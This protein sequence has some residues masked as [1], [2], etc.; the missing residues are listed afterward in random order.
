MIHQDIDGAGFNFVAR[1]LVF[2]FAGSLLS[3]VEEVGFASPRYG[4]TAGVM[5]GANVSKP[6]SAGVRS[7]SVNYSIPSGVLPGKSYVLQQATKPFGSWTATLWPVT[8]D[9]QLG[10]IQFLS[11]PE[12]ALFFRVS[13]SSQYDLTSSFVRTNVQYQDLESGYSP[14]SWKQT[15]LEFLTR[16]C[17]DAKWVAESAADNFDFWF[18]DRSS[19]GAVLGMLATAVHESVHTVGDMHTVFGGIPLRGICL[20]KDRFLFLP[21][22]TTFARSE[23]ASG[24]PGFMQGD[25][26]YNAYLTGGSGGQD[27]TSLLGEL[28]AYTYSALIASSLASSLP[29]GPGSN[30]TRDGLLTMMVYTELYLKVYREQ[31]SDQYTKLNNQFID[32]ILVLWER[33]NFALRLAEQYGSLGMNDQRIRPIVEQ[34]R[35]EIELVRSKVRPHLLISRGGAVDP[36]LQITQQPDSQ[37][38][39]A[40]GS[41]VFAVEAT[42]PTTVTQQWF[43]NGQPLP[44]ATNRVLVIPEVS[45]ANV[46]TYSVRITGAE[47][48]VVSA[49]ALLEVLTPAIIVQQPKSQTGIPAAFSVAAQGSPPLSYQWYYNGFLIVGATNSTLSMQFNPGIYQVK[50]T[51]PAGEVLS[52]PATLSLAGP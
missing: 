2:C 10:A 38:V 17:P 37:I 52:D 45:N 1:L 27:F 23:I 34:Y 47:E 25:A 14:Q 5:R 39:R 12:S 29:Q 44:G 43:F 42:G 50:A 48:T 21:H 35:S 46:G 49:G 9:G 40:G 6:Q 7:L 33:A 4:M 26:Y 3:T 15:T 8:A 36:G 22:G 31:H 20:G 30:S 51:N 28:N 32:S 41:A 11:P 18:Q 16:A 19:F 24:L 13:V